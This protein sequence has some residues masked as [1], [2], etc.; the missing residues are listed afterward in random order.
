LTAFKEEGKIVIVKDSL[1][2][3]D[4]ADVSLESYLT[5]GEK[6]FFS[7]PLAICNERESSSALSCYSQFS[8]RHHLKVLRFDHSKIS[9]GAVIRTAKAGD[10]FTKFGGGTK[11][12]GDY[13]TDKKIPVRLRQVI[14]LLVADNEVLAVCGVEISDKIKIDESTEQIGCI[15]CADYCKI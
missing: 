4:F 13:F 3:K 8:S 11:S 1:L 15:I 6:F 5:S 7:Q 10:K 2:Y 9:K 12:L 14:P